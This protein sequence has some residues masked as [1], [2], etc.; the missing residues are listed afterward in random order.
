MLSFVLEMF[1]VRY[2]VI[3]PVAVMNSCILSFVYRVSFYSATKDQKASYKSR[4]NTI[5]YS[6]YIHT[7]V[8]TSHI[9]CIFAYTHVIAT[10]LL[11][12]C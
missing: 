7:C 12:V 5:L 10:Q 4:Q 6:V 11:R 9:I 8:Y 3:P 1:L 2:G